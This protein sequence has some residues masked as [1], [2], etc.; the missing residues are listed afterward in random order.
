MYD[1]ILKFYDTN[2]W[3]DTQI[4]YQLSHIYDRISLDVVHIWVPDTKLFAISLSRA[5]DSCGHGVLQGKRTPNSDHK[6]TWPQV[7]WVTQQQDRQFFLSVKE[8]RA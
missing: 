5:D 7:C 4:Q 3:S 6:L 8:E 2:V 1:Q